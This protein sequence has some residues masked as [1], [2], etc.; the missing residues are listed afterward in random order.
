MSPFIICTSKRS[1][2]FDACAPITLTA[3]S[4]KL[5]SSSVLGLGLSVLFGSSVLCFD[6]FFPNAVSFL[7]SPAAFLFP[8]VAFVLPA[9]A[10]F[11]PAAFAGVAIHPPIPF[12]ISADAHG[13]SGIED[14][15]SFHVESP[16]VSIS[17]IPAV[18]G[19]LYLGPIALKSTRPQDPGPNGLVFVRG[20][21]VAATFQ[22]ARK[23]IHTLEPLLGIP[24]QFTRLVASGAS[25]SS[26]HHNICFFEC[27]KLTQ[28]R[29]MMRKST[30]LQSVLFC[31]I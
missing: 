25:S 3:S 5:F 10:F 2:I 14:S 20:V 19:L 26:P 17:P 30:P 6:A 27:S 18:P 9:P 8:A 7:P 11:I 13:H 1:I 4:P 29:R 22:K 16:S 12:Q 28:A 15:C 24:A 23:G 31:A 21:E